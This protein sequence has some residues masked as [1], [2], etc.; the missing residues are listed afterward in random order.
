M[1]L[2]QSQDISSPLLV[3]IS[4]FSH[5]CLPVNRL[6]LAGPLK[7]MQ[8]CS[9]ITCQP[10]A[11]LHMPAFCLTTS[12]ALTLPVIGSGCTYC[13]SLSLGPQRTPVI[14]AEIEWHFSYLV[15]ALFKITCFFPA[16]NLYP[17][18]KSTKT[19][20][21]QESTFGSISTCEIRLL[22]QQR[23]RRKDN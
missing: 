22:L 3:F 11:S 13:W 8:H 17:H 18:A 6:N 19:K 7:Q 15:L 12:Q 10:S 1:G 23:W 20:L 14:T 21:T 2:F 9:T 16:R 4:I 5:T